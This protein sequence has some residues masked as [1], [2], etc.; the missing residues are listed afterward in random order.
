MRA[1]RALRRLVPRAVKRRIRQAIID[2]FHRLW[3]DSA[4]WK[5]TTFLGYPI[6]QLPQDLQVYQELVYKERPSFILQTGVAHGGSILYFAHLLD[7]IGAPRDSVVIGIDRDLRAEARTLAHPRIRLVEGDSTA[8]ETLDRVRPLLPAPTGLV[9]LDSDHSCEHVLRELQIYHPFTGPG[10]H[11]VVED[12]N[13]NGHPVF[14]QHGPGPL[15]AVEKF[16]RS[17]PDFVR[18]D[19]LWQRHLFSFHQYGWLVRAGLHD[20]SR[21]SSRSAE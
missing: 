1:P 10:Q 9:S 8:S 2:T 14:R 4:A 5:Q 16:L 19:S 12:T 20:R 17:H 6:Q 3:Y 7:M 21:I 15:E 18:D 11:L 13:I